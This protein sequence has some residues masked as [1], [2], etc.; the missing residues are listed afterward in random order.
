MNYSIVFKSFQEIDKHFVPQ[1]ENNFDRRE[2]SGYYLSTVEMKYYLMIDRRNFFNQPV[3][4]NI[5]IM[6]TS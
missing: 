3:R 2:H 6:K 5:R 4:S 1:F